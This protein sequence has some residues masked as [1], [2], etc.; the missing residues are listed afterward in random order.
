M[1]LTPFEQWEEVYKDRELEIRRNPQDS[2]EYGLIPACLKN[3][4]GFN[5]LIIPR[6]T[7]PEIARSDRQHGKKV[8]ENLAKDLLPSNWLGSIGHLNYL[9]LKDKDSPFFEYRVPLS[10]L[11]EEHLLV[12][13][14]TAYISEEEKRQNF[15]KSK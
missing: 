1:A 8:L 6:G 15:I 10:K 11:S 4:R 3:E 14:K 2:E 7:F 13:I 9:V 5:V 12:A